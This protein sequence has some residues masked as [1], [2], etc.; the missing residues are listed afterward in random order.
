L[1]I[2]LAFCASVSERRMIIIIIN[3]KANMNERE[4]KKE[5]ECRS[6]RCAITIY[7]NVLAFS[8]H[9]YLRPQVGRE[10]KS[11]ERKN[12]EIN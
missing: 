8:Y 12:K 9:H 2:V 11:S 1:Y 4:R 3:G 10:K 6:K 7:N 5:G